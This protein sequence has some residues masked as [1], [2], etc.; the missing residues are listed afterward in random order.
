MSERFSLPVYVEHA[1]EFRWR[2]SQPDLLPERGIR[3]AF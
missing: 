3:H 1:I 2:A